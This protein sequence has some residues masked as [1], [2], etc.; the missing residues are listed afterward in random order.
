MAGVALVSFT[1]KADLANT[2][3]PSAVV[4]SASSSQVPATL[5]WGYATNT[6]ATVGQGRN[7]ASRIWRACRSSV[8]SGR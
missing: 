3:V 4:S 7:S 2:S 5:N 6:P 1:G 8:L